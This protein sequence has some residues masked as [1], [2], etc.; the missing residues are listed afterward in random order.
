MRNGRV[1]PLPKRKPKSPGKFEVYIHEPTKFIQTPPSAGVHLGLR[2]R[3]EGKIKNVVWTLADGVQKQGY[4]LDELVR[5]DRDLAAVTEIDVAYTYVDS[6][7]EEST[8]GFSF[9]YVLQGRV[10]FREQ[11]GSPED[12]RT[13]AEKQKARNEADAADAATKGT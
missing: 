9:R 4:F 8:D 12:K 5:F 3:G 2:H 10:T 13:P 6:S 7:G 1:V 11:L